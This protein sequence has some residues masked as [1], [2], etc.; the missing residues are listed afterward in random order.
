M[1]SK[2][3]SFINSINSLFNKVIKYR[4]SIIEIMSFLFSV[5]AF[6]VALSSNCYTSKMFAKATIMPKI[7]I[8]STTWEENDTLKIG[9]IAVNKGN[10]NA[11]DTRAHFIFIDRLVKQSGKIIR[12]YDTLIDNKNYGVYSYDIG[13]IE[14]YDGRVNSD[15]IFE[16]DKKK[17]PVFVDSTKINLKVTG[18]DISLLFPMKIFCIDTVF[19]D[20][21]QI[22]TNMELK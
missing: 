6:I 4:K 19:Y 16:I 12:E 2:K 8:Q 15:I 20:T 7:E 9:I 10:K 22:N 14:H 3:Q 5:A 17:I 1:K 11:I 18:Q 13:L 21:I